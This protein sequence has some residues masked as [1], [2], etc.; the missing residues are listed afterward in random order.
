MGEALA[1]ASGRPGQESPGPLAA[2]LA[3]ASPTWYPIISA[4][5]STLVS[6]LALLFLDL[7]RAL[8]MHDFIRGF[9]CGPAP[10]RPIDGAASPP[11]RSDLETRGPSSV[12]EGS[13]RDSAAWS[14]S[15][16]TM[17]AHAGLGLLLCGGAFDLW[18]PRFRDAG[19]A[20]TDPDGRPLSAS[21]GR[22]LEAS[23]PCPWS[24]PYSQTVKPSGLG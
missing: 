8:R 2:T 5:G 23:S 24:P 10:S 3:G 19:G 11:C 1:A 4:S 7:S 12:P 15:S 16:S 20:L 9:L 6:W 22:G 18:T 21:A 13:E 14:S 17:S